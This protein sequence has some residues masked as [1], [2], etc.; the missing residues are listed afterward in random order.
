MLDCYIINLD[1]AQDRWKA[2]SEKFR[3]LG[4]NVIRVPALRGK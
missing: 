4:L 2:T 3:S 1:R